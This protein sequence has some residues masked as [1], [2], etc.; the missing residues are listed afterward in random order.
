[1]QARIGLSLA[2][3]AL[4][5]LGVASSPHVRA[6]D[7]AST[8]RRDTLEA[9]ALDDSHLLVFSRADDGRVFAEVLIKKG[10]G[11]TRLG[12]AY[13]VPGVRREEKTPSV[14]GGES[15]TPSGDPTVMRCEGGAAQLTML[16]SYIPGTSW[17]NF[18]EPAVTNANN[19]AGRIY[20]LPDPKLFAKQRIVR[21][22]YWMYCFRINGSADP[23]MQLGV[24]RVQ[25]FIP[26]ESMTWSNQPAFD[27]TP[28]SVAPM[29]LRSLEW[30][31]WDVTKLVQSWA[32]GDPGY[33]FVIKSNRE[34]P[35]GPAT[36]WGEAYLAG[37]N[38]S[39]ASLRPYFKIWTAP[40]D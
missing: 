28:E 7:S 31:R 29:P 26:Y 35:S 40:S 4:T 22:E 12:E 6:A 8:V 16:L 27:A 39:D 3:T 30:V 15:R 23:E 21:A 2:V 9:H 17:V 24:H 38:Y 34:F 19:G 10:N 25:K 14:P 1:M 11:Y 5:V 36:P 33:G 18:V 37:P 13:V 20:L 32:K